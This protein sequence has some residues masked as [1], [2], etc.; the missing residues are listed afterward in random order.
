ME[1]IKVLS[2]LSMWAYTMDV[3]LAER[4]GQVT[5]ASPHEAIPISQQL[6]DF[7]F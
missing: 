4:E 6:K 5:T 7:S 3:I 2:S 1:R